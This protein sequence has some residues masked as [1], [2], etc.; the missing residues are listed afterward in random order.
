MLD[1][2]MLDQRMLDLWM[3]AGSAGIGWGCWTSSVTSDVKSETKT[4]KGKHFPR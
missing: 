4:T 1:Q 2:W 3:D